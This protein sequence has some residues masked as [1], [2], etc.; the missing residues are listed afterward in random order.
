MARKRGREHAEIE[1]AGEDAETEGY[2]E[3]NRGAS[4][5]WPATVVSVAGRLTR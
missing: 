2:E 5:V 1:R 3:R 4:S